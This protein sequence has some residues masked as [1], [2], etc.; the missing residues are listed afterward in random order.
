VPYL[1]G[2][3]VGRHPVSPFYSPLNRADPKQV[4]LS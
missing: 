4:E 2:A 1:A 3:I